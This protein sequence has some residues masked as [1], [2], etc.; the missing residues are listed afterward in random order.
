[1][2][3]L[4]SDSVSFFWGAGWGGGGGY[5]T[6]GLE[7][8][9]TGL[10]PSVTLPVVGDLLAGALDPDVRAGISA[11]LRYG[12]DGQVN[13]DNAAQLAALMNE[14]QPGFG[15]VPG[16]SSG[17][18][19]GTSGP[20]YYVWFVEQ[21]LS[22]GA[23]NPIAYG[24]EFYTNDIEG[25]R[26]E[27]GQFRGEYLPVVYEGQI[28]GSYLDWIAYPSYYGVEPPPQGTL[29]FLPN[30][31]PGGISNPLP[32]AGAVSNGTNAVLIPS[33]GIGVLAGEFGTLFLSYDGTFT[34]QPNDLPSYPTGSHP[35][36]S[37]T[38][39]LVSVNGGAPGTFDILV[40]RG[41]V[42]N[43]D[44]SVV[45]AGVGV[46][47]GPAGVLSNDSDPDGDILT[48]SA[49]N[50]DDAAVGQAVGGQYG[51][52]V[53]N[54]DGSFSY[55]TWDLS[56]APSGY[57]LSDTFS[58]SAFDGYDGI[59]TADLAVS[60]NRAPT[61]DVA[62]ASVTRADGAA[63]ADAGNGVLATAADLDGDSL[64]VFSV[65]GD[66]ANVG[67]TV[68]GAHGEL[69]LNDDGSFHYSAFDPS[70]SSVDGF[71]DVFEFVVSDGYG[72]TALSTLSVGLDRAPAPDIPPIV[73]ELLGTN[74]A[75]FLVG[76]AG[77]D[78]L[79]GGR[80]R[81]VL[82]G[83]AGADVF[84]FGRGDGANVI[85]DFDFDEGDRIQLQDGMR[86]VR[87][88]ETD[89]NGD[90]FADATLLQFSGASVVLQGVTGL[91]G[92]EGLLSS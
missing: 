57:R 9:A 24:Y 1:M 54:A 35:F 62:L 55:A 45:Q 83:G 91:T 70:L 51:Q 34:Y 76:T 8:F 46:W 81:D 33:E 27:N 59:G 90:G 79:H 72:G 42:A 10:I 41:P 37:F 77:P 61:V 64:F 85:T 26:G 36:D 20:F 48:V 73:T 23:A 88:R 39:L 32:P 58:Y 87:M 86:I 43:G 44:F 52:L 22:A 19:P 2:A 60:I 6:G 12:R 68:Q 56:A 47:V 15:G 80:G 78:F 50:G 92:W 66:T 69:L 5:D 4:N 17:A 65:S 31:T 29:P 84:F 21:I 30:P 40:N 13:P 53:L 14:G 16:A 7:G 89:T 82:T 38:F 28:I 71:L 63:S 3:I 11:L 18:P 75:D 74:R 25:L 49:V 67:S